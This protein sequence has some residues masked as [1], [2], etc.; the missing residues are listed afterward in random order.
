[1][2]L[3]SAFTELLGVRYPIVS[4]PMGGS[5]GGAL[6]AAVSEGSGLDLVGALAAEAEAALAR[7]TA[8]RR[9]E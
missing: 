8:G 9:R 5:A 6:A 2:A 7:A 3:R 4:A 1:M